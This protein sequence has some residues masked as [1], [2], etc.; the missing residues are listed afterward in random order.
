LNRL[1]TGLQLLRPTILSKE[2]QVFD[3]GIGMS[4]ANRPSASLSLVVAHP[5]ARELQFREK[6]VMSGREKASVSLI[7]FG[8]IV[9]AVILLVS[10][11]G[12]GSS[13]SFPSSSGGVT[14]SASPARNSHFGND[15]AVHGYG[16]SFIEYGGCLDSHRWNG[17]LVGLV[18][19]SHG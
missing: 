14:V 1:V 4:P 15:P 7:L 5:P 18:H 9:S 6:D 17:Q 10:C 19:R 8:L 3:D 2:R 13:S 12:G 11:G 16:H